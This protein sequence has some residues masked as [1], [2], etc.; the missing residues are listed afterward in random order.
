MLGDVIGVEAEPIISL[1]DLQP[2]LVV[3]V[4]RQI[5]AVEMIEDAEFHPR[6]LMAFERR[7]HSSVTSIQTPPGSA[8][9]ILPPASRARNALRASDSLLPPSGIGAT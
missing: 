2:R 9:C 5:V 4:Q 6:G 7:C 8:I 3:V 1:D